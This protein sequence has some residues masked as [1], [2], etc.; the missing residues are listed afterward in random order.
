MLNYLILPLF[1]LILFSCTQ[2]V[3]PKKTFTKKDVE[4]NWEASVPSTNPDTTMFNLYLSN[5]HCHFSDI[6]NNRTSYYLKGNLLILKGDGFKHYLRIIECSENR[7][8]LVPKSDW[9]G[10]MY[11]YRKDD[12]LIFKKMDLVNKQIVKTISFRGN[13]SFSL[14]MD[15]KD[16]FYTG[17]TFVD[18]EGDYIGK[19][20]PEFWEELLVKIH[21]IDFEKFQGKYEA[22]STDHE[23]VEI[24]IQTNTGVFTCSVYGSYKEPSTIRNL[25][26]YISSNVE[27]L[28]MQPFDVEDLFKNQGTKAKKISELLSKIPC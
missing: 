23:T 22:R 5:D 3:E 1:L 13:S 14:K 26:E 24:T 10:G 7:L 20:S 18:R 25:I 17:I 11:H 16:F 28:E 8:K 9:S 19:V 2:T 4:G 6:Q 21:Y 27:G 15:D 12:T